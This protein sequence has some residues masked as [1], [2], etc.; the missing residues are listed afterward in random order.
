MSAE[1]AMS[2]ALAQRKQLL[3]AP[4]PASLMDRV[5]FD[6]AMAAADFN[7]RTAVRQ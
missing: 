2:A 6:M 4:A 5:R 3:S 1:M 7:Y